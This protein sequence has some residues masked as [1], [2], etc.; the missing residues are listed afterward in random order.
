MKRL[1]YIQHVPFETP[2]SIIDWART[3]G[4]A[5]SSSHMYKDESFPDT[6]AFDLLVVMGGSMGV[7]DGAKYKWLKAEKDFIETALK[8]DK[9]VLGICLGAQLLADVLGAG[10]RKNRDKEIGWF[11]VTTTTENASIT[12]TQFLPTFVLLGSDMFL[13][14]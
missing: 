7:Q 11:P 12:A 9:P 5:L 2:G 4:V 6:G 14:V 13:F 10:V 1:H 3:S 8:A